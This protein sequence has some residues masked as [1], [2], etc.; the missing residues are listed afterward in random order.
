VPGDF[1]GDVTIEDTHEGKGECNMGKRVRKGSE[2]GM[3]IR[4]EI[5]KSEEV[6]ATKN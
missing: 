4:S 2:R 6:Q 1:A 3:D 5:K